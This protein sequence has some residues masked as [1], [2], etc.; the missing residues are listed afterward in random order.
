[1]N[2]IPLDRAKGASQF[3]DKSLGVE[4]T[5]LMIQNFPATQETPAITTP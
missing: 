5:T 3:S 4:N 2:L 1:M